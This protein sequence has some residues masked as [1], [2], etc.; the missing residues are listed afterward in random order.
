MDIH[1]KFEASRGA[2]TKLAVYVGLPLGII[3]ASAVAARA[4][5]SPAPSEWAKSGQPVPAS[6]L[7]SNLSALDA[8]IGRYKDATAASTG[9]VGGYAAAKA[10]CVTKIGTPTAHVCTG[11]EMALSN[12]EG[13]L[14]AFALRYA[15]GSFSY[16]QT[17][18]RYYDDCG[19]F[20]DGTTSHGGAWNGRPTSEA[21]DDPL[22][23]ACCD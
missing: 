10:L 2:G 9:N 5:L 16:D 14:P 8:R 18:T 20:S 3:M 4:T 15:A 13:L 12:Q 19:G 1:I 6:S 21:C 7:A 17:S 22:G 23:I 11:T